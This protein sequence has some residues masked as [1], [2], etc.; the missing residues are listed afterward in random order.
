MPSKIARALC[1]LLFASAV[2]ASASAQTFES[3]TARSAESGMAY[4]CLHVALLDSSGQV[5]DHTVTDSAGQFV[6]QVP[7]PTAYRVEFIVA[8]WE[9][10]FGPLD[11]LKEGDFRERAY[12]LDFKT[13]IE[14]DTDATA[15]GWRGDRRRWKLPAGYRRKQAGDSGWTSH[16][17]AMPYPSIDYPD[18]FAFTD[19]EGSIVG[20]FVVDS[21]GSTRSG[22][23]HTLASTHREFEANVLKTIPTWRWKPARNHGQPVCELAFDLITFGRDNRDNRT[24][25]FGAR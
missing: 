25:W 16:E 6:F 22:S 8:H 9:P 20:R 19:V 13:R 7:R 14:P 18:K 1:T 5:M 10:L 12:A 2:P 15:P 11:T 24:V 17:A 4:E 23:W 3:G 21:T